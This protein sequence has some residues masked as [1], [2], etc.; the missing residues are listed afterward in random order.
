VQRNII[1]SKINHPKFVLEKLKNK[2][3]LPFSEILSAEC[4]AEKIRDVDY[5]ER[6]F[7]PDVVIWGFLSQMLSEDQSCQG[8]VARI[9]AFCVSQ[10]K[11]PPSANTA[12]YCKART[13]LSEE[14]ISTIAKESAEQL[15]EDVS[16]DWLWHKKHIKLIDGSTVFMP[17]TTDNQT[18]YPQMKN[19]KP[20][21][22]FPIAR[23]VAVVSYATGAVLDVAIS[24][25]FG[26][27]AG[28]HTLLRDILH[29]FK[30]G[31]VALGDCYY[32]SFFL[33][34][35]LIEMGVDVVFPIHSHRNYDFRK[36]VRLGKKD[37]IIQWK[38]PKKP[39]WMS[40]E[41]YVMFP[42]TISIREVEIE[43]QRRG[44]RLQKRIIVT[45]FLESK[46]ISK[47]DLKKIYDYRWCIEID[48]KSIKDTM[49]MGILR[50][51][52][53][54][55]IRKEIWMH[56]L[57]YNLIRKIMA[58]AAHV[59]SRNPRELSFKLAL[60]MVDAFRQR[61][62]FAE[63]KNEFYAHLLKAVAYKTVGNR[64]NRHEPRRLKRRPKNYPLLLKPRYHYHQE[65]S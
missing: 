60:Q 14:I 45:T 64:P 35:K 15:E 54:K 20:G 3:N 17:D 48:F 7:T 6:I 41:E 27:G 58:Q 34:A 38:K 25:C 21:L 22:G 28:E 13:R 39:D 9:I 31:D 59:H 37:H 46:S 33:I 30:P 8:A 61:G 32:A 44:F 4:I 24:R 12:A 65:H 63:S 10:G 19:Q 53:P 2:E 1:S 5:R 43:N 55:M 50:S 62:T 16:L 51:K 42:E 11:S 52:T 26:K 57:A 47:N 36:G 23:L 49:R 56:I 29:V 40:Y 18:A